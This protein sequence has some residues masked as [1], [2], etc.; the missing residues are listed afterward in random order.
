MRTI[1]II[2]KREFLAYFRSPIA[3]V[4]LTTYLVLVAFLFFRPFFVVG[5]TDM[6]TFFTLMPWIFLFYVPAVSMGKWA[7]ERRQGTL[8]LL[9][10]MPVRD[11]DVV[12]GKFAAGMGLVGTAL[13]AS[14]PLA[15][16]VSLLGNLDWGPVWGG[17]CG[18][19]LLGGSFMS[20]GLIASSL[21]Q[22]QIIAFILGLTV[23]FGMFILGDPLVTAVLPGGVAAIVQYF[24][25]GTHFASMSRGVIDSRDIVYYVTVIG[26]FLWINCQLI[27]RRR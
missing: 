17:Y 6:R 24:G 22:S 26:M 13:A 23:S 16:S 11:S 2:M 7:D 9:L 18:L 21:T 1:A 27:Q 12:L 8:E 4:F 19:L 10:T 3:Y 25:L 14:L 5:Q 15:W 20:I